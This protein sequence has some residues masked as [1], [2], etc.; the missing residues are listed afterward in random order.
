MFA[1]LVSSGIRSK[2]IIEDSLDRSAGERNISDFKNIDS[3]SSD[4]NEDII[5]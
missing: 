3:Q 4:S 5:L 1:K 2:R